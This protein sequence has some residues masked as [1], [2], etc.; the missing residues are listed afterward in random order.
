MLHLQK[1]KIQQFFRKYNLYK[2]FMKD[3]FKNMS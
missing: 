1:I 3:K 2:V